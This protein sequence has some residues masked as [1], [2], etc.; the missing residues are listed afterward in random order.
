VIFYE[1]LLQLE[2]EMRFRENVVS[3]VLLKF[4]LNYFSDQRIKIKYNYDSTNIPYL[5]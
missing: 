2:K 5:E 1:F 4:F 3:R